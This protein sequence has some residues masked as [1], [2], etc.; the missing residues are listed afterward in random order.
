MTQIVLRTCGL[1]AADPVAV[2]FR[3]HL[4]VARF[5]RDVK[6]V[7]SVVLHEYAAA[8]VVKSGLLSAF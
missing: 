3:K 1:L 8:K 6:V 4:Y 2:R 5:T 7:I